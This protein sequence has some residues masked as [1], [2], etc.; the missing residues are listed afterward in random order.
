MNFSKLFFITE[1]NFYLF[2]S[3][4]NSEKYISYLLMKS[5]SDNLISFIFFIP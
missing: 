2:S 1:K 4:S 3:V 5:S